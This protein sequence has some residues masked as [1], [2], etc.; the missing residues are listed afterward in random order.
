MLML[1]VILAVV[2]V[3]VPVA[4][5]VW[6]NRPEVRERS[7]QHIVGGGLIAML[8]LQGVASLIL[9]RLLGYI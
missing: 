8:M 5:E 6:R 1:V 2:S 7:T 3:L 4:I 9:L